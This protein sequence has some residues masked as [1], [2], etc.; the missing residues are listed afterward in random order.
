MIKN[1]GFKNAYYVFQ[2]HSTASLYTSVS[3]QHFIP[4]LAELPTLISLDADKDAALIEQKKIELEDK[5]NA[6][7][8]RIDEQFKAMHDGIAEKLESEELKA[9]T[10][11]K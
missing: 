8:R 10:V 4:L 7:K 5:A 1:R 3:S 2:V 9:L 11:D 6:T